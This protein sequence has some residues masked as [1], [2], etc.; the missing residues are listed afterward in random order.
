VKGHFDLEGWVYDGEVYGSEGVRMPGLSGLLWKFCPG[1]GGQE[2]LRLASPSK[3]IVM[4][5]EGVWGWGRGMQSDQRK[6]GFT[7]S[8]TVLEW[9]QGSKELVKIKEST[10]CPSAEG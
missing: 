10:H 1:F 3:E 5:F 7:G 6:F 9:S 4:V 2:L 8:R